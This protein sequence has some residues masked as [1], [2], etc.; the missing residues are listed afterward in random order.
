MLGVLPG[1]SSD[2]LDRLPA[3]DPS[4][5]DARMVQMHKE[6]RALVLHGRIMHQRQG[7]REGTNL[8]GM[9]L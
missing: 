8:R 5:S 2:A 4:K 9:L 3:S 1:G 7:W 6:Q